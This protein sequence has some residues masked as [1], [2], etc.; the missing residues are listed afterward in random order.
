MRN[1]FMAHIEDAAGVDPLIYF[2][3]G[4][5][6]F[7]VVEKFQARHGH[8]FFNAGIAEQN[9]IGVAAGLAMAGKKPYVYSII[10]FTTLRCYEQVRDDICYQELP[11]KLIG[12]GAGYQY[13]A[14]GTTHHALEDVGAL[15][16]LP[17]MT[18]V[19]PSSKQELAT[20][21]PQI[22]AHDGPLYLRLYTSEITLPINPQAPLTLGSPNVLIPDNDI[23]ILGS[24]F[25]AELGYQVQQ[26]LT[27]L[28]ITCGLAS[29]HT[30]LPLDGWLAQHNFKAI[31]TIEDHFVVGGLG[32]MVARSILE[33]Y[34]HRVTFKAFGAAHAYSHSTGKTP[35][36]RQ[37]AG[38]DANKIASEISRLLKQ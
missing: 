16:M 37:Q 3:T 24:G 15:R 20:L 30:M 35:F 29:V 38:L 10:P 8:R 27:V 12:V 7:S 32:E 23:M 17:G 22:I 2:I 36:L 34:T 28:G 18:V 25:G 14:L 4:D 6:G 13:G 9:M 5:L 31:F 33:T 11:V 21:L 26:A 19:T 1:A